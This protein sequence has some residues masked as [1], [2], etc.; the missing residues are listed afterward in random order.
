MAANPGQLADYRAGKTKLLGYFVG[1][2]MQKTQ[3][4]AD[5]K[6]ANTLLTQKLQG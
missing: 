1:Q 3:G 2:L 4:R 5:P 6:L